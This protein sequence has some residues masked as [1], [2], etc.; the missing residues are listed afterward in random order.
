MHWVDLVLS[1]EDALLLPTHPE[2]SALSSL[3]VLVRRSHRVKRLNRR[4]R[5]VPYAHREATCAYIRNLA[6][7]LRELPL[8]FALELTTHE[9]VVLLFLR[10]S[11]IHVLLIALACPFCWHGDQ[12]KSSHLSLIECFLWEISKHH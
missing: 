7:W 10:L 1:F 5:R 4:L 11:F 12:T 2:A 9:S 8:W 3:A 6:L